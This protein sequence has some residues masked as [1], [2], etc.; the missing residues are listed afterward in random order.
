MIA[1][2]IAQVSFYKEFANNIPFETHKRK[3]RW[4]KKKLYVSVCQLVGCISSSRVIIK[5]EFS[6]RKT[7]KYLTL[8]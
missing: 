6:E 2:V 4:S 7:K 5:F 8:L 3:T 1:L